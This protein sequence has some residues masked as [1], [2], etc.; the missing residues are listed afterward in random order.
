M[1]KTAAKTRFLITFRQQEGDK[2]FRREVAAMDV[3]GALNQAWKLL[4]REML[5]EEWM[6]V[7]AAPL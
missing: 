3:A 5:D 4:Q 7:S 2:E 1:T 6:P